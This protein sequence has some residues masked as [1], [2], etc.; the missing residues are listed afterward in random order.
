MNPPPL[1]ME[2]GDPEEI[3]EESDDYDEE[4]EVCVSDQHVVVHSG[5]G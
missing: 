3:D 4:F 1:P 5:N 2:P